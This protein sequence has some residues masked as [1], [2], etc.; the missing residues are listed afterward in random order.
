M[1]QKQL[2]SILISLKKNKQKNKKKLFYILSQHINHP[3]PQQLQATANLLLSLRACL[4]WVISEK[5]NH[6]IHGDLS[7]FIYG[8]LVSNFTCEQDLQ[9][10]L[11]I[12]MRMLSNGQKASLI[13]IICPL[14]GQNV[15]SWTSVFIPF[16]LSESSVPG[17]YLEI[18]YI[19]L[20]V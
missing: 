16:A 10:L 5:W 13:L 18:V 19:R 4:L 14:A 7:V 1:N 12:D 11:F 15:F 9:I 8:I 17:K 2:W 3:C 20:E 6:S